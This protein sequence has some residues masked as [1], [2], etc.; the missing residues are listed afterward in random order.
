MTYTIRFDINGQEIDP[1]QNTLDEQEFTSSATYDAS[2]LGTILSS[3]GSTYNSIPFGGVAVSSMI[4]ITSDYAINI[5]LDGGTQILQEVKDLLINGTFVQCDFQNNSGYDA[6]IEYQVY[7]TVSGAINPSV[8]R[9]ATYTSSPV[10][11]T[12]TATLVI[13]NSAVPITVTLPSAVGMDSQKIDIKTINVGLVTVVPY[14]TQTI[15][16]VSSKQMNTIYS[17]YTLMSNNINWWIV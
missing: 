17:S 3:S 7:G 14:G 1:N 9:S 6:T 10:T 11:L 16:N 15:D 4:R 2:S 8:V 13:I 12:T 5:R